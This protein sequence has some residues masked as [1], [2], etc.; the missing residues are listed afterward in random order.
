MEYLIFQNGQTK[1]PFTIDALRT[2]R[3]TPDTLVLP[4]GMTQWKPAGQVEELQY[5]FVAQSASPPP[6]HSAAATPSQQTDSQQPV[7][8]RTAQ[9]AQNEIKPSADTSTANSNNDNSKILVWWILGVMLVIIIGYLSGSGSDNS[10]SQYSD[11]ENESYYEDNTSTLMDDSYSWLQGTWVCNTIVGPI[12]VTISGNQIIEDYGNGDVFRG[13]YH[14][15]DG[16]LFPNT[17]SYAYYP[18]DESAKKIGDGRGG[19]FRKQ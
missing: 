15:N 4:Q 1:G 2:M 17:N 14:I 5:L 19:Y 11:S 8:D 13:T 18:L 3:I 10:S 16:I 9:P 7:Y 12:I 6:Y